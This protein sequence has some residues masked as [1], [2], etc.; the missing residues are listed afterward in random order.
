MFDEVLVANR[1]EIAVRVMAADDVTWVGPTS[2]G[3]R[4]DDAVNQGDTIGGD[5]DSMIAK[6]VVS[7]E[8]REHC[9]ER[10]R[11]A[12]GHFDVEGFHTTISFHRLMLTDDTFVSGDHTT[13][14]LDHE[15]EKEAVADAVERWGPATTT[16]KGGGKPSTA[17][18][19]V[20]VDGQ[21]FEVVVEDG[22]PR[23]AATGGATTGSGTMKMENDVVASSGGTVASVHVSAGDSVDMGDTLVTLE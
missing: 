7:A 22:L 17:T 14:C 5:Y 4:L 8:D 16:G 23:A 6:L 21:R 10:S 12:L 2:I 9:I 18:L 11:R 19:A 3:V 15:L 20:E 1:G 13:K